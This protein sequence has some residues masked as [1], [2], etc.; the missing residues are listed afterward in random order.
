MSVYVI[1]NDF[2]MQ[3][4]GT[5]SFEYDKMYLLM[6]TRQEK[7]YSILQELALKM[8]AKDFA[9]GVEI[10]KDKSHGDLASN[11]ALALFA[12]VKFQM[13]NFKSPMELA[14]EIVKRLTTDYSLLTTDFEEIKVAAPGFINFFFS[15]KYLS[16]QVQ[17]II[18]QDSNY[19][20]SKIGKGRKASVEF[21]S[22]NP[23]GPLHI[24]NARGGP[25][26]DTIANVLS[27]AG[28]EVTREYLHNDVGGQVT[29]LGA[30]MFFEL[31]PDKTP[32]EEL[33][34][35]GTYIKELADKVDKIDRKNS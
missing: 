18:S 3:V 31:N 20:N 1:R 13:S 4:Q 28:Y 21:V 10:P 22:A 11:I 27:K 26:G 19:G 34:Y 16:S 30:T 12:N 25:L 15:K 7:I 2:V 24:G 8:G 14:Q 35:Q 29:K 5:C 17:E 23:T 6:K 9:F 33:M 32:K